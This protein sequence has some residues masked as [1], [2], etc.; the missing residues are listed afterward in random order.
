MIS[1]SSSSD[2][3]EERIWVTSFPSTFNIH[4]LH[5]AD[6]GNGKEH[7]WLDSSFISGLNFSR[8][9]HVKLDIRDDNDQMTNGEFRAQE[10]SS[11]AMKSVNQSTP[12]LFPGKSL[13]YPEW[14]LKGRPVQDV[15][16]RTVADN[17]GWPTVSQNSWRAPNGT[18]SRNAWLSHYGVH[19]R[20]QST[21]ICPL[22]RIAGTSVGQINPALGLQGT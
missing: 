10:W 17:I 20:P 9:S 14:T 2:K 3:S 22:G 15:L 7:V 13:D 5:W 1:I 11:D 6:R 16:K 21:F 4:V 12:S 8:L 19:F 18:V